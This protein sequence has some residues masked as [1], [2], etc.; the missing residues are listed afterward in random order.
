MSDVTIETACDKPVLP[1]RR[2]R[3][4]NSGSYISK[5]PEKKYVADDA[6]AH[7]QPAE[8]FW[9]P[10]LRPAH[11]SG[12][13]QV[14]ERPQPEQQTAQAQENEHELAFLL[15][16]DFL[17]GLYICFAAKIGRGGNSGQKND[18][19]QDAEDIFSI[20]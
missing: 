18:R 7:S 6:E 11:P 14:S 19:S 15:Q 5:Q 1:A 2:Y 20:H 16:G 9:Q 12:V 10:S 3:R 13:D 4:G 8:P 17:T